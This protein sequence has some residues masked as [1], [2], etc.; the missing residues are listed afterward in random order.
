MSGETDLDRLFADLDVRRMP[1]RYRFETHDY[2]R[3][4]A[5][6]SVR[7]SEGWTSVVSHGDGEWIWLELRVYSSLEAV[8]F[9][10]RISAALAEAGIPCNA[11]AGFYHDHIFVPVEKAD[12]AEATILGLKQP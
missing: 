1:G 7:E 10:A 12:A 11:V 5:I 2:P 3:G 6:V 8:G 4:S 9:L